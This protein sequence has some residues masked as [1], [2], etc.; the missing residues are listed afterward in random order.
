MRNTAILMVSCPDSKGL[1]ARIS[2]YIYRHGGN[3]LDF[4]QHTDLVA[5]VFLARVEWQLDG[6][7]WPR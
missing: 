2:E 5:G 4:D 6:F 3:I 7:G 1:V